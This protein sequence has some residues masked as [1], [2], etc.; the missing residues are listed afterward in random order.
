MSRSRAAKAS[1]A[2]LALAPRVPESIDWSSRTPAAAIVRAFSA[3]SASARTS[4]A[5]MKP[6]WDRR[7]SRAA[8]DAAEASSI[9]CR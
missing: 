7:A 3:A 2:A 1:Y 5:R 4:S 6:I 9:G 8:S